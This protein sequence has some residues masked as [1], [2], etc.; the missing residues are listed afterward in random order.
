VGIA[1]NPGQPPQGRGI[2]GH[3]A[4][5]FH[6]LAQGVNL[7]TA[8]VEAAA[9]AG[10]IFQAVH[11]GP[12]HVFHEHGLEAGEGIAQGEQGRLA[13]QTGEGGEEGIPLAENHRRPKDGH[14]QVVLGGQHHRLPFS[15]GAEVFGGPLG[16]CLQGAH[17]QQTAHPGLFHGRHH[18][19]GQG[20]MGSG[21]GFA[22]GLGAVAVENPHQIDDC[23]LAFDQGQ[24][25]SRVVDVR[26]HQMHPGQR[27][28]I[29]GAFQTAG[30]N[31]DPQTTL[32]GQEVGNMP[33]DETAT[34]QQENIF[35]RH[36]F[37]LTVTGS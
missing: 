31:G 2:A 4:H 18:L 33:A 30:G 27:Q 14:L 8:K 36:G 15:L 11:E 10:R 12:G 17:V 32:V 24:E 19:L 29:P 34:A 7:G 13:Q 16:I 9:I 26:F 22:V 1:N 25:H 5:V 6:Q 37:P 3:L 20:H 35:Q 28:E 21:K 23:V